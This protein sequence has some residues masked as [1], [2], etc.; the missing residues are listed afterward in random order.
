MT[1]VKH[2]ALK[3]SK[4]GRDIQWSSKSQAGQSH[5]LAKSR[6]TERTPE[7]GLL[8]KKVYLSPSRAMAE[9]MVKHANKRDGSA[10]S[11]V[12]NGEYVVVEMRK[13]SD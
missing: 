8:T 3:P 12:S 4:A 13:L 2:K 10:S 1:K 9:A 6:T 5:F 11:R 7:N